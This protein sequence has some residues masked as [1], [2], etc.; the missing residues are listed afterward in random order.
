MGLDPCLKVLPLLCRRWSLITGRWVRER[1]CGERRSSA[2]YKHLGES[3][4]SGTGNVAFWRMER[5]VVDRFLRLLSVGR[6]FLDAGFTLQ[7][8]QTDRAV[9]TCGEHDELQE[10]QNWT[11]VG[12]NSF[13]TQPENKTRVLHVTCNGLKILEFWRLY[14]FF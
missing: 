6:E 2:S 9:V 7:V 3:I 12:T 14:M 10:M 5:H 13:L 1:G 4:C 11:P 8:P